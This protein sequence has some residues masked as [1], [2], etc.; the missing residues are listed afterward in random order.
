MRMSIGRSLVAAVLLLLLQPHV[1][2]QAPVAGGPLGG[3]DFEEQ[4]SAPGRGGPTAAGQAASV[5][6]PGS[7][8]PYSLNRPPA[9]AGGASPAR[10]GGAPPAQGSEATPERS[11][12]TIQPPKKKR[13]RKRR[14]RRRRP[15]KKSSKKKSAP[16]AERKAAVPST[17]IAPANP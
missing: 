14:K 9:Q 16:K 12:E 11:Q 3:S 13:P 17:P 6:D 4:M 8:S 15:S 2:A 5:P 7:G 10:M 1:R